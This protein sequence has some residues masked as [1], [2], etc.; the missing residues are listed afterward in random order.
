MVTILTINAWQ[1]ETR[2]VL[3]TLRVGSDMLR[4][5]DSG[6]PITTSSA[7]SRRTAT[8]D[9]GVMLNMSRHRRR[10][11]YLGGSTA[12]G[13]DDTAVCSIHCAVPDYIMVGG[14]TVR[15]ENYRPVS[16]YLRRAVS[17]RVSADR[18]PRLVIAVGVW[19]WTPQPCVLRPENPVLV[20]GGAIADPDNAP[21]LSKVGEVR[22][23]TRWMVRASSNS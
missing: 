11:H 1:G 22:L 13:D 3:E 4:H 18:P 16:L 17:G 10:H 23:P 20:L 19:P 2:T 9:P 14:G 15:A 7:Q 21:A 5:L 8:G 12:L 6:E